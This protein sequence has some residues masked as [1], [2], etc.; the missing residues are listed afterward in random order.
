MAPR[1]LAPAALFFVLFTVACD[2]ASVSMTAPGTLVPAAFT[3]EPASLRPEFLHAQTCL[4]RPAFRLHLS[5]IVGGG[6]TVIVHGFR[7]HFIDRAGSRTLP[8]VSVAPGTSFTSSLP[9]SSPIPIPGVAPLT[10]FPASGTLPFIATFGC[11][12][13]PDG[14]LVVIGDLDAG[15][16]AEMRLRVGT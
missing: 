12:V 11:D 5:V 2:Q 6:G 3:A 15:R 4:F 9:S 8:L 14:T 1:R 10:S 13:I 7:F 16:T